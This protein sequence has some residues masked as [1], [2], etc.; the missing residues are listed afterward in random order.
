MSPNPALKLVPFGRLKKLLAEVFQHAPRRF[1]PFSLDNNHDFPPAGSVDEIW[2]FI[3]PRVIP[4]ATTTPQPRNGENP[5]IRCATNL[6]GGA[7]G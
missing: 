2:K 5:L 1:I 7:H 3:M 4:F 6:P